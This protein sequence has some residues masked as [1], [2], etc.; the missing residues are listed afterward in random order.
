MLL[1][2][3]E[4]R[5]ATKNIND[6]VVKIVGGGLSF[7]QKRE[8]TKI[9]NENV[10]LL[11]GDKLPNQA[12][13]PPPDLN[14]SQDPDILFLQEV[15]AGQHDSDNVMDLAQKI[16]AAGEIVVT[17]DDALVAQAVD[18]WVDIDTALG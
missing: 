7:S 11:L 4:K 16:I 1:T 18:K 12:P 5:A 10:A 15:I 17:S 3:S 6:N 8:S 2:F 14:A 13:E 9:I